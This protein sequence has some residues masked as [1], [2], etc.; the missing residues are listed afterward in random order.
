MMKGRPGSPA[1]PRTVERCVRQSGAPGAALLARM[2][3]ERLDSLLRE[4]VDEPVPSPLVDARLKALGVKKAA[5]RLSIQA[6]LKFAREQAL[7]EPRA[8]TDLTNALARVDPIAPA[9]CAGTP[10]TTAAEIDDERV[11]ESNRFSALPMRD[12]TFAAPA[13]PAA[14]PPTALLASLVCLTKHAVQLPMRRPAYAITLGAGVAL[15]LGQVVLHR[16][17]RLA[18]QV[19]TRVPVGRGVAVALVE[20]MRSSATLHGLAP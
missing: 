16:S 7:K 1:A 20:R 18:E 19:A 6:A 3:A 15:A 4:T 5:H 13:A 9:K 17:L 10:S 12:I 2:P 11:L 14:A 8:L